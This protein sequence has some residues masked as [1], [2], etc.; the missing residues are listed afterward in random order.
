MSLVAH[1]PCSVRG[2]L[3]L[4]LLLGLSACDS[5]EET[6]K[7]DSPTEPLLKV[8]D[9]QPAKTLTEIAGRATLPEDGESQKII[10][11][12]YE[13]PF[14]G[15]YHANIPCDDKIFNSLGRHKCMSCAL[16]NKQYLKE[17]LKEE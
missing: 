15:R 12:A 14:V 4:L 6:A 9:S 11:Q 17:W 16:G 1:L 7:V 3:T 8:Q 5:K 13:E 10:L 2:S